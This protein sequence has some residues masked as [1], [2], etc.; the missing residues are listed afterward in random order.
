MNQTDQP[1]LLSPRAVLSSL[2]SFEALLVLY[3][4]AGIYKTDPRFAWLPANATALFFALS[5]LVGSFIIVRNPIPKKSLPV[6]FAMVCLVAWLWVGVTWSPSRIYGPDKAFQMTSLALWALIAGAV[7]IA[8]SPERLRRLFTVILLLALWAGVDAVLAYAETGLRYS[9]KREVDGEEMGGHLL[10]GRVTAP[11]ALIALAAWLYNRGRPMSW[12]YLGLFL[13]L[14]FVLAI[15]GGRGALLST[16]LPL[17][18]P[19]GLSLRLT[20]RKIQVFRALLSVLVLLLIAAGGLALYAM[21]T[22]ERLPT[23]DRLERLQE[24]NPRI[25]GYVQWA[26]LWPQAPLLG[27]GTGSWP[28]LV[29]RPDQTIYPHNLFLELLVEN[30]VVGLFLFLVVVGVALRPVSLERLRRDPRALC[31]FMFFV[32]AL[33][34]AMTSGD[35]PGNR[36]VFLMLGVLS[37]FAVRPVAAATPVKRLPAAS[38]NLPLPR[39]LGLTR[40]QHAVERVR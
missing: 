3:M 15:G 17:L 8:P 6:V 11:G 2:F 9:I 31:A 37:L 22:G 10:L 38:S 29:G 16:M 24:G 27:H 14:G 32:S 30:G 18:I 7:I 23:F 35:L 25:E 13:A 1:T 5:V 40:G 26:G 39:P 28:L 20:T 34:N 12:I 19:I 4:F 21:T 36:T 33:S